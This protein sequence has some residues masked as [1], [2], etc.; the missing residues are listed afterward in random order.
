MWIS[1]LTILNS[2]PQFIFNYMLTKLRA[3][4]VAQVV[5]C[6]LSIMRETQVRFLD[7][8]DPLEKEVEKKV[9][10]SCF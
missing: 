2:I 8:E 7:Q 4:L 10:Y 3:F 9:Q 6:L 5:K 1:V